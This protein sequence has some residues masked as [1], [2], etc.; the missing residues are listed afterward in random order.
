MLPGGYHCLN[1]VSPPFR[2]SLNTYQ[3]VDLE[4]E[5][6]VPQYYARGSIRTLPH[7]QHL[8]AK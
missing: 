4:G 2:G 7:L 1:V 8:A 5:V 3:L 6:R